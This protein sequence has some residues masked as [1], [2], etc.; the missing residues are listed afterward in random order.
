MIDFISKLMST[1]AIS[2]L[3]NM[4][5][6]DEDWDHLCRL[7]VEGCIDLSMFV[8]LS[9]LFLFLDMTSAGIRIRSFSSQIRDDI[10]TYTRIAKRTGI[11]AL[12]WKSCN[13]LRKILFIDII[14][15]YI[16]KVLS[17]SEVR[18]YGSRIIE[19]LN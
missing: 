11:I 7:F 17:I 4:I 8:W 15:S 12:F 3:L 5:D 19:R 18:V 6:I 13:W 2:Y 9:R 10:T 16:R 14:K 1:G